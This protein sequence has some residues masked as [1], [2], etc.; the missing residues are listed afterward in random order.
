M[1]ISHPFTL[2]L[3]LLL[4]SGCQKSCQSNPDDILVTEEFV[5]NYP[6]DFVTLMNNDATLFRG[7]VLDND[8]ASIQAREDQFLKSIS[9][10]AELLGYQVEF[11]NSTIGTINYEFEDSLLKRIFVLTQFNDEAQAKSLHENCVKYYTKELGTPKEQQGSM[12]WSYTDE[13]GTTFIELVSE[14]EFLDPKTP[15]YKKLVLAIYTAGNPDYQKPED[16]LILG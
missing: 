13:K 1:R 12:V 11:E 3:F 6:K 5:A 7:W 15:N 2:V 9:N 4:F 10:S 8:Y 14:S 16:T